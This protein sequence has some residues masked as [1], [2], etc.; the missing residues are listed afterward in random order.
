MLKKFIT[1]LFIAFFYNVI[2]TKKA[3]ASCNFKTGNYIVQ[4]ST[5]S[6]IKDIDINIPN[7][8][9]F[10]INQVKTFL[11]SYKLGNSIRKNLKKKHDAEVIVNY[12][13]GSCSYQGKIWQNGDWHDHI[14]NIKG[15]LVSSL[16]VKLNNGNILNATKFKLLIPKTRNGRHEILGSLILKNLGFISP[17]T[18]EVLVDVNDVKSRMIFQEDS[19]KELLERRKRRE[20]PIFEG[21]ESLI[22]S[23]EQYAIEGKF[24]SDGL[25]AISLSRLI[26]NKWFLKSN[27][28]R[29]IVLNSFDRLQ[30]AYL[31]YTYNF[32]KNKYFI[33]PN[34]Q[35]SNRENPF[36]DYS[37]LMLSMYGSHGLRPHNRKFYFNSFLDKFEPIYY[38]GDFNFNK[39]IRD[40]INII[41]EMNFRKNY[42]FPNLKEIN[43]IKF[44]E[45]I[46][47][48]FELRTINFKSE[49]NFS[50][51]KSFEVFLDNANQIQA[52][53]KQI[54]YKNPKKH[55]KE[56]TRKAFLN[57]NSEFNI[58]KNIIKNFK[59]NENYVYLYLEDER[60]IKMRLYEFSKL[61][62]RKTIDNKSYLFLPTINNSKLKKEIMKNNLSDSGTEMIY[63][64]NMKIKFEKK[65]KRNKLTIYQT[66]NDQSILLKGGKLENLDIKFVGLDN[67]LKFNSANGRFNKRGLTGCLNIYGSNLKNTSIE[68]D[69]GICEDSINIILS[70]GNLTSLNVRNAF[71]DAVDFDFSEIKVDIINV[72]KAGN[73]CIDFSSGIYNIKFGSF[74]SC[75]D[76]GIS[77]G[78]KSEVFIEDIQIIKSDIGIAVKDLS[79]VLGKKIVINETPI[80]V[81]IFQKK[82][83][84]GGA[85]A[86]LT[87]I[88]CEGKINIDKE[89]TLNI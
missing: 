29:S 72:E 44:L 6:S 67:N 88:D 31:E 5:P 12:D 15:N 40:K 78:E 26:N 56:T 42:I 33:S 63:P 34:I 64:K 2:D 66:E 32:A 30:E 57:R 59:I 68:V 84:F 27:N 8:R 49:D 53:I 83:E 70:R 55:K 85:Y 11:S 17:E 13:F 41:E 3:I 20:G 21:D 69:G 62:S 19:Q 86:T 89:S 81:E 77:I 22:W 39:N 35:N 58:E 37:F 79:T 48:E 54:N 65:D 1:F 82:Q 47:K 61:L 76:K 80:C 51:Q 16:N 43:D 24:A 25:E 14:Q 7:S 52:E 60:I 36:L 4:L 75:F 38:D 23:D 73:D 71:Q 46:R 10:R 50:F 28:S 18:F 74:Q 45:K 87:D 9:K